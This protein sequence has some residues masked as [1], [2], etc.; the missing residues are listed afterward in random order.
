MAKKIKRHTGLQ[1]EV[2][3]GYEHN[4]AHFVVCP[5]IIEQG[6]NVSEPL[7]N[8]QISKTHSEHMFW[9]KCNGVGIA[10]IV[11]ELVLR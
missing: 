6:M 7:F 3:K 4:T 2:T 9:S 5:N 11:S 10:P 8:A 1:L